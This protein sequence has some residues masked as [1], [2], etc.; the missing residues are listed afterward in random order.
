M[1]TNRESGNG[2]GQ[3]RSRAA[4]HKNGLIPRYVERIKTSEANST[5]TTP[6]RS[7]KEAGRATL[8]EMIVFPLYILLIASCVRWA[9]HRYGWR[10]G[11]G[12]G[13][14][15]SKGVRRTTWREAIC[16]SAGNLANATKP[17]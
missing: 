17:L 8:I 13:W 1:L 9:V 6:E 14:E 2:D 16:L 5:M 15:D 3:S 4:S 11:V 7:G 12:R 10:G